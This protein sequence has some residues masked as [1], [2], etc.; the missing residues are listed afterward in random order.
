M[1]TREREE[2]GLDVDGPSKSMTCSTWLAGRTLQPLPCC[3]IAKVGESGRM[4]HDPEA[5]EGE[6]DLVVRSGSLLRLF[7]MTSSRRRA[8]RPADGCG[9]RDRW[10]YRLC[11]AC[12]QRW[13]V[14]E[15]SR[16]GPK[17]A[18]GAQT[19][20]VTCSAYRREAQ[21]G[22]RREGYFG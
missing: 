8:M 7:Y 1:G 19:R 18:R 6:G 2:C 14:E 3:E 22:W 20:Q 11:P 13:H 10:F 21:H 4:R 12:H 9:R 17:L 15:A 5:W 16:T